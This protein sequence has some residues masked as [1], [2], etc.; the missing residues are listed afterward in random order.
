MKLQDQFE[1]ESGY[2]LKSCNKCINE[3]CKIMGLCDYWEVYAKWL[4]LKLTSNNN[5]KR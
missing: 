5:E 3:Q 2:T 1:K 4:E